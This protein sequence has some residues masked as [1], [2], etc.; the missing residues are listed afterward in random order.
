MCVMCVHVCTIVCVC[1]CV[2]VHVCVC[3][4]TCAKIINVITY[5]SLF[6]LYSAVSVIDKHF[7]ATVEFPAAAVCQVKSPQQTVHCSLMPVIT[8][9]NLDTSLLCPKNTSS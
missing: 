6:S 1:V 4:Y 3:V 7:K 8:I 9:V 2:C 5:M